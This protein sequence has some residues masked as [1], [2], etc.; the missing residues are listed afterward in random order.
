MADFLIVLHEWEVGIMK[1]LLALVR[2]LTLFLE[3]N[4]IMPFEYSV[5]FQSQKTRIQKLHYL[6]PI[7]PLT[8]HAQLACLSSFLLQ[9]ALAEFSVLLENI[10]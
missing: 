5:E 2:L 3:T 9:A 6:L 8:A 1:W 10:Q 4:T 7:Y